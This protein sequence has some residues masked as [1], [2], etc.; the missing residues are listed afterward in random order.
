MRIEHDLKAAGIP[1]EVVNTA[2]VRSW[3]GF[4][5]ALVRYALRGWTFHFHTNG[6]NRKSWLL[7][8]ACGM[9]GN[10]AGGACI[11]TLHSGI[12]PVWLAAAGALRCALVRFTCLHYTRIIGVNAPIRDA[13]VSLEIPAERIDVMPAFLGIERSQAALDPA[14]LSWMRARRPLLSTALFFRPEYGFEVLVE[15]IGR[16]RESRT[17]IGCIVM[18]GSDD[19]TAAERLL[20]ERGLEQ[21]VLL[22]GDIDHEACLAVM[23]ASDVFVRATLEDGDSISVRE[24]LSLGTPVVASRVGTRPVGAM[25]FEPGDATEL[26]ARIELALAGGNE[27]RP[28]AGASNIDRLL[29]IYEEAISGMDY[30]AA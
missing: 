11:L 22:L 16:L 18:G 8:L 5:T 30:A 21:N 28:A 10:L 17:S 29:H 15:A 27:G 20:R 13:L 24:A 7:A 1:C 6:H 25:L 4:W 19:R 26:A 23:A 2:G 14:V 12:A 3:I 9:V